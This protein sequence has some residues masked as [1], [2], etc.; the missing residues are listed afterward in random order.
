MTISDLYLTCF[1]VGFAISALSLLMGG[2]HLHVHLPI[3]F[4]LGHVGHV[5]HGGVAGPGSLPP[6]NLGTATAFLAWFG[7][8]GF[9][10]TRH[11]HV[12]AMV[13]LLLSIASGFVGATLV[14]L[15]VTRVLLRFESPMDPADYD[16]VGVL[17]RVSS[18][19]RAG[20]TGEIIFS[21][22]GSRCSAAA[23]SEDGSEISKDVEVVV[24]R[25]ER[26]IAYVR[27]WDELAASAGV[28]AD[29]TNSQS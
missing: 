15:V 25:Y 1:L 23:R 18:R 21:R 14:F 3:H 27:R 4:H 7:G 24:T 13:A 20:G 10:L 22:L 9:L 12:Y 19:L 2:I 26:G 28:D 8:I 16:M 11:S 5:P 6:I 17:G 29:T